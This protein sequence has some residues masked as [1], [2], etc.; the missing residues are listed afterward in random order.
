[1][2]RYTKH[3]FLPLL[4]LGLWL[5]LNDSLSAGYV[6]LGL[7]LAIA[8]EPPVQF[9]A[10][11][12][13]LR[14]VATGVVFLA[15]F[16]LAVAFLWALAP[17]FVR[18][19]EQLVNDWMPYSWTSFAPMTDCGTCGRSDAVEV[20]RRSGGSDSAEVVDVGVAAGEVQALV[21]V[22]EGPERTW[23]TLAGL[24]SL[25]LVHGAAVAPLGDIPIE[26]EV[27]FGAERAAN[28]SLHNYTVTLD[29]QPT[30]NLSVNAATHY[31]S[32][33]LVSRILV[34][35][36]PTDDVVP[37]IGDVDRVIRGNG[38]PIGFWEAFGRNL[39][40]I[41]DALER[42]ATWRTADRGA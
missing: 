34:G 21:A 32:T 18:Q 20:R 8:L 24:R 13:W 7:F 25:E 16:V 28:L 33:H 11:R 22:V 6:V 12:G 2:R 39:M 31:Q 37:A 40:R 4:L 14:G 1:M 35:V 30:R 36:D 9:L 15:A 38:Q 3:L 29:W 41:I 26:P 19:V 23:V 10:K 42:S 27:L 5:L 17:L